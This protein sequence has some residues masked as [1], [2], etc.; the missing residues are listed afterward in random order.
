[1][2]SHSLSRNS[3]GNLEF[4]PFESGILTPLYYGLS[5][6]NFTKFVTEKQ[7]APTTIEVKTQKQG[8]VFVDDS[9]TANKRISISMRA[10][11][12]VAAAAV[13]LTAVF[14]VAFPGSNRQGANDKQQIKSGVLYNIFRFRRYVKCFSATKYVNTYQSSVRCKAAA[15]NSYY[16]FSLLGNR[17]GKPRN[18]K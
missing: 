7:S 13:F 6:F 14:L 4:E 2:T 10:V 8:V 15:D 16:Y 3:E 17:Y 12:N 18:R 9:D 1:M 11:R 5:S